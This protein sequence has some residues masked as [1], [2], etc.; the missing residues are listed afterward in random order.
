MVLSRTNTAEV[1]TVSL[2][3][4]PQSQT[5]KTGTSTQFLSEQTALFTNVHHKLSKN[6][7][8]MQQTET[9]SIAIC[10]NS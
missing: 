9:E 7:N 10:V 2:E 3:V 5:M 6:G 8:L 1:T 4:E